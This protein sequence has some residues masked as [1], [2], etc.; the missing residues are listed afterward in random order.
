MSETKNLNLFLTN[1]ETDGNDYFDFER[2]LNQNWKK[3]DE[4]IGN[5]QTSAVGLPPSICSNLRMTKNGQAITL[6]WNEPN[7]TVIDGLVLASWEK[8]IIVRKQGSYPENEEDGEVI[9]INKVRNKYNTNVLNDTLPDAIN[10]YYYRAF[11]VSVNGAICYDSSN[12]FGSA[13]V[14]EFIINE[15]NSN[16]YGRIEYCGRNANFRPARMDFEKGVFDYGDW[17]NTFIMESFKPV[18][19]KQTGEVDY[20]LNP[21]NVKQKLDGTPSDATNQSYAGNV[22]VQIAQIWIK[23]V[24]K[25]GLKHIYIANQQVDSDYDCLSHINKNNN[26]VPYYYYAKYNGSTINNVQRSISGLAPSVNTSGIT[27]RQYCQANGN[28]HEVRECSF[29]RLMWYLHMLVGHTTNVQ[30]VFGTGRYTGGTADNNRAHLISGLNDDKG[31]FH[32]DNNNGT[33]TTFF[34][35]NFWGNV[36]EFT[37]GC[38]QK[39]GKLLYKMTPN[40]YDGS[41]AEDYNNDGTGYLDSGVDVGTGTITQA[42][43]KETKLVP[44]IGL[45]PSVFTGGSATTYY[46][47]GFWTTNVVGF[48]RTGGSSGSA[49]G[50]LYGLFAFTVSAVASHSGWYSGASLSYKNPL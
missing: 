47:D 31:M 38:I 39:N 20:F 26:L 24:N 15:S 23:E 10:D 11:P 18:M 27:Q 4:A 17:K 22:M 13:I 16:P 41:T 6:Q 33:V 32:G 9:A 1:M 50:L 14:Y 30:E 48:L 2:D 46:C 42:Y 44:K 12:K 21:Y 43:I 34:I 28:G 25:N 29:L 7:D 5:I 8:T 19:L 36:W 49:S 40:T 45:V 35:D 37:V 3:I